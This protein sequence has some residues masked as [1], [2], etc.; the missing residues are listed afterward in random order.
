MGCAASE[1]RY[2]GIDELPDS[3]DNKQFDEIMRDRENVDFNEALEGLFKF[4]SDFTE[5]LPR[6]L[7][8]DLSKVCFL[9]INTFCPSEQIHSSKALFDA[10]KN[11]RNMKQ[12][13]YDVF[14]LIN[15]V[16]TSFLTFL[17]VFLSRTYISLVFCLHG[18][19]GIDESINGD[20]FMFF[21]DR[22][23]SFKTIK[24]FIDSYKRKTNRLLVLLDIH[25][26]LNIQSEEQ[27]MVL[28]APRNTVI[29]YINQISNAPCCVFGVLSHL[30]WDVYSSGI[31]IDDIVAE[32]KSKLEPIGMALE[33]VIGDELSP[34]EQ[35]IC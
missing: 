26:N 2:G 24:Q 16:S 6:E 20:C 27:R 3:S 4:G 21:S 19:A 15:P 23:I 31:T 13:G 10:S 12:I 34:K 35:I 5:V 18:Y 9:C 32:M 14:Y 28:T 7:P 8:K 29:F 25:N 17:R 33:I 1:I 22:N 11:A 30:F